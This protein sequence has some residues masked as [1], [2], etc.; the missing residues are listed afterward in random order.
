MERFK[1][2][3][4]T[5]TPDKKIDARFVECTLD[6]LDA[7]E[8]VVRVAYSAREALE[9][10]GDFMPQVVLLDIGMPGMD[11][12]ETCRRLRAL[13]GDRLSVV[14]ISGWGQ[15]SDKELARRAGFDAHL[16]KPADPQMLA[17]TVAR[18]G[19]GAAPRPAPASPAS[20]S[21]AISNGPTGSPSPS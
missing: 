11:G 4:L 15:E 17:A 13:H 20:Y 6:E 2:F 18:F 3:K 10:V 1:A 5:E 14:A 9:I 7:G 8:V 12:Y 21:I 16:T 19:A